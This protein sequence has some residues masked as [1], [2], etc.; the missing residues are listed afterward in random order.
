[1]RRGEVPSPLYRVQ[2]NYYTLAQYGSL[3]LCVGRCPGQSWMYLDIH[4]FVDYRPASETLEDRIA[5]LHILKI[6]F[7]VFVVLLVIA[8]LQ[9]PWR[10]G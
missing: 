3:K 7:W 6:A 9:K 5:M 8:L 10:I 4:C 2:I 1:M